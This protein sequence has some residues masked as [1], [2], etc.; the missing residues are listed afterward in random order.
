MDYDARAGPNLFWEIGS[1]GDDRGLQKMRWSFT[2]TLMGGH[3][4]AAA[5]AESEYF[6][7]TSIH[8]TPNFTTRRMYVRVMSAASQAAA[9]CNGLFPF[10]E[11]TVS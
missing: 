7:G 2:R 10:P 6:D 8:Q 4:A 5:H 1:A 9:H 3:A 11:P